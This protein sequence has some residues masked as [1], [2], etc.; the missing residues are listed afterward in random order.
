MKKGTIVKSKEYGLL[1]VL[2]E[3]H[4]AVKNQIVMVGID[5]FG[6]KRQLDGTEKVV[7]TADVKQKTLSVLMAEVYG[8]HPGSK[9]LTKE[10]VRSIVEEVVVRHMNTLAEEFATIHF[11][12]KVAA[13]CAKIETEKV[14]NGLEDLVVRIV[15]H[16]LVMNKM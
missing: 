12:S 11:V 1:Y 8:F 7:K 16:E 2:G 6:V 3:E 10:E 15:K 4:N 13:E 9:Y 14:M 5:S